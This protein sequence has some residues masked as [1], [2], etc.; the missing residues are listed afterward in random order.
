[1][2]NACSSFFGDSAGSAT[3]NALPKKVKKVSSTS[4]SFTGQ[5]VAF[6]YLALKLRH[7]TPIAVFGVS[8]DLL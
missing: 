4:W 2:L 5:A 8:A 6:G 7:E 1:M 3:A